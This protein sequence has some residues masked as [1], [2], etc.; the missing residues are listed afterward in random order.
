MVNRGINKR[1]KEFRREIAEYHLARTETRQHTADHFG[2]S[3]YLVTKAVQEYSHNKYGEHYAPTDSLRYI[4]I[5]KCINATLVILDRLQGIRCSIPNAFEAG[6]LRKIA[7]SILEYKDSLEA[8]GP[9]Q[10]DFFRLTEF[11]AQ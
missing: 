6:I 4:H 10:R 7:A 5:S 3:H 9:V 1:R 8:H 2:V 11:V